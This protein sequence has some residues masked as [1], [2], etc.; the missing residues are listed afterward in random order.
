[1]LICDLVAVELIRLSPNERRARDVGERLSA[2]ESISMPGDLW[3]D[4]RHMQL[5]LAGNGDHRRVPPTDLLLAAAA[6]HASV[7]LVHY[8]RDYERIA[9]VSDLRHQWFVPSGTLVE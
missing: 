4:A 8:D 3:T 5:S 7:E 2:F 1:M 9:A 6:R